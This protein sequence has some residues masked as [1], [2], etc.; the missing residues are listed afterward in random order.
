LTVNFTS[1]SGQKLST[2]WASNHGPTSK[3]SAQFVFASA[4]G[5]LARIAETDEPLSAVDSEVGVQFATRPSAFVVAVKVVVVVV[6][7][8]ERRVSVTGRLAAGVPVRVLR[9]WQVI[10]SRAAIVGV[11]DGA[12]GEEVVEE[13]E[14]EEVRWFLYRLRRFVT[15]PSWSL[16][17]GLLLDLMSIK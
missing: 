11:L 12:F 6:F 5:R 14:D 17:G 4:V 10:G 2:P 9:T 15:L 3:R 7:A 13:G 8:E 16:D 1:T